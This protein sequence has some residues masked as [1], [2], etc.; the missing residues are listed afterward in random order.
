MYDYSTFKLTHRHGDE[1]VELQPHE[2]HDAADHDPER[3]WLRHPRLFRCIRCAEEV[4]V[5]PNLAE[6]GAEPPV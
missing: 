2:H 5:T 1:W 4:M 3:G 6:E